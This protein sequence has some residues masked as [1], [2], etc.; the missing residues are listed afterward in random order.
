MAFDKFTRTAV[1]VAFDPGVIVATPLIWT[2][3][4]SP[5]GVA[6]TAFQRVFALT[7]PSLTRTT[8]AC[9]KGLRKGLHADKANA[10]PT[11]AR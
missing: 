11:R 9:L 5:A 10:A 6:R 8:G 4:A 7:S 1:F 3:P 2:A